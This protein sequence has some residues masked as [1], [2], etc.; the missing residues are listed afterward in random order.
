M[1]FSSGK[2]FRKK[3]G[4]VSSQRWCRERGCSLGLLEYRGTLDYRSS[5]Y[6][7]PLDR[8]PFKGIKL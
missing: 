3:E 1:S 2:H 8:G 4:G 5:F 6:V 7:L